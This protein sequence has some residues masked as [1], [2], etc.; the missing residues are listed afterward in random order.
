MAGGR[1]NWA[2]AEAKARSTK[3]AQEEA[4]KQAQEQAE[5]QGGFWGSDFGKG[6]GFV[7]NNPVTRAVSMP[8]N[9]LQTGGRAL[10]LG[11]ESLRKAQ[12]GGPEWLDQAL[13]A[14]PGLGPLLGT[15]N[16]ERIAKDDR[17]N[18]EKVLSPNSTYGYGSLLY[19]P[20]E[21]DTMPI[22][23]PFAKYNEA[24]SL[25]LGPT[26]LRNQARAAG[27][28]GDVAYDPLGATT[29]AATRT[30]EKA[31]DAARALQ[32]AQIAAE[33]L[34]ATEK[35]GDAERIA[36]ATQRAADTAAEAQRLA[37]I[38]E[39]NVARRVQVP[40]PRNRAERA[41]LMGELTET[42]GGRR[43]LTEMP[44]E[45]RQ[46]GVRGFQ[47]MS[48]EARQVLGI[49]EPGLSIR[50]LDV[51]I[52][53]T[54][55]I[56]QGI[57]WAGG[58]VRAGLAKPA[59]TSRLANIRVPR[60]LEDAFAVLT[61]DADGD[62]MRAASEV[63]GRNSIR[64]GEGSQLARGNRVL[65]N[66]VR[67]ELKK[68]GKD[69]I[70]RAVSEAETSPD[71]NIINKIAARLL[72]TYENVTGRAIDP[73]N[74]RDPATYFPHVL[75][76]KWRRALARMEKNRDRSAA[77]FLRAS[78]TRTE[79]LLEDN[80]FYLDNTLE[81]SGFLE[82]ARKLGPNPDGTP[83]TVK[84][85][86]TDVTFERGDIDHINEKLREAFPTWKGDFYDTDP[87]RVF[88]AYN[89][90]LARQA[91]RDVA[92][93]KF[94]T[95]GNPL[96]KEMVGNLDLSRQA[97][98]EALAQQGA[99]PLL[100]TAQGKYDPTQ[101]LPAIP[102]R[103]VVPGM[104]EDRA[105]RQA[106]EAAQ[107]AAT[108]ANTPEEAAAHAA[109]AAALPAPTERIGGIAPEDYFVTTKG[110]AA[111]A[112][113]D[114]QVKRAATYAKAAAAETRKADEALRE[115]IDDV[116]KSMVKP[117][118]TS[119]KET[120]TEISTINK[121]IKKWRKQVTEFGPMKEDNFDDMSVLVSKVED[122]ILNI[123]TKLK[124][125]AASWKG[126][127][128]RAQRKSEARLRE[129]LRQLK[130]VRDDVVK[131]AEQAPARMRE[132]FEFRRQALNKPV[133]DA[134]RA[135]LKA[136]FAHDLPPHPQAVV[137]AARKRISDTLE[138]QVD[139][140]KATMRERYGEILRQVD[141]LNG[142]RNKAGELSQTARKK[143]D[144]LVA[145]ADRLRNELGTGTGTKTVDPFRQAQEE[146]ASLAGRRDL[147]AAQKSR[148]ATL[149][150]MFGKGG[151]HY[152]RVQDEKVL[153][154]MEEYE[155]GLAAATKPQR[156]ALEAAQAEKRMRQEAI[157]WANRS[158]TM[159]HY[160]EEAGWGPGERRYVEPVESPPQRAAFGTEEDIPLPGGGTRKRP[161]P[162]PRTEEEALT[163]LGSQI[164]YGNAAQQGQRAV[165][166]RAQ[167]A[168]AAREAEVAE[169]QRTLR[170]RIAEEAATIEKDFAAQADEELGP[171]AARAQT[172]KNLA[173][174]LSDKRNLLKKRQE[175]V[176]LRDRLNKAN[177]TT[178][179]LDLG[180]TIDEIE[181]VAKAN[182]LLDDPKLNQ[183][184]SLLNTHRQ[185]LKRVRDTQ[186]RVDD[187]DRIVQDAN[188]GKLGDVM[189]A[190]LNNNWRALHAG[191]LNT[192]DVIMDAELHKRFTNLFELNRQPTALGRT[193]NAFTNLF[194]TYATLSPGFFVRNTIGGIF[195]N[196]ADGVALSAQA[197]GA[198]LFQQWMSKKSGGDDWLLAQ[199]KRVQ[200]AF[201][202]AF[203]SGAGGRF[204]DSGVLAQ[205][206]SKLYNFLSSNKV[207]RGAQ[208]FGTRVEGA[209][210]L[211]MALDSIDRGDD[212]GRAV[213]RITRIHF[214]YSQVS[215]LDDT[216]KRIIPFWTFMS[217][218]LP[219]QIQEMWTN[220]RVYSY[221][222]H[223]VQNFS[224]PD[225]EFT[226]DYWKRQGA[227]RTPL[228]IGGNPIYAQPDL[229]FTRVQQDI[230]ML[231]DALGGQNAG[232]LFAQGNPLI[233]ATYDFLA[234]RDS[235]Y[236][237]TY[238][239]KDYSKMEGPLGAIITP[240][241]QIAGQ[242]NE[243]G[244]VSD[245][246]MNYLTS[247]IPPLS[248]ATRIAPQVS[249][250]EGGADTWAKRARYIGV[251]TQ[252]LTP[253]QQKS[254]FWRRY[255]EQTDEA[256]RVQAMLEEA[257]S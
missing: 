48:P 91:G 170:P 146:L 110:T 33:A 176:V 52:P 114:A 60:G 165:F 140:A 16:Q 189:I 63:A 14:T 46:G 20:K 138:S 18:F 116:R 133:E 247:L 163:S 156:D 129:S 188:N 120:D 25:E 101:P 128:T 39:A 117:L 123:E 159:R 75:D 239:G 210:R 153:A 180:R 95:T 213:Q 242:T 67:Q 1:V 76:P 230:Q 181:S 80:A 24:D 64:V 99:A 108:A 236:D 222:D 231:G 254:E 240:L 172:Y 71:M 35:L 218:N 85:G 10:T 224:L 206:N 21:T 142:R 65:S 182:P 164:N 168:A 232:A 68:L 202:A 26:W 221:Y 144:A 115:S 11:L 125:T 234:H 23:N 152:Q 204:E 90:S 38:P 199:P 72:A 220:P 195:M 198:S 74:L 197:E 88:E 255:F 89:S 59:G 3:K 245:N 238:T 228:S 6:L 136:E 207:T 226:P 211:G 31:S 17:S 13:A 185:E 127:A 73:N 201:T 41:N 118:R 43:F 248:Q 55:K 34:R 107:A 135:L 27:L 147:D 103:P 49:S 216:M 179:R 160:G 62:L 84:I 32:E 124:R 158:K 37:A 154:A 126:R 252:L 227:W 237:R 53:G 2:E 22:S 44:G 121:A 113:R 93:K 40:L 98:D 246:F 175:N 203:T 139:P 86:D 137:D 97:M 200:D 79:E 102:E 250:G 70:R 149:Q 58:G 191:P 42:E 196:T 157:I 194:K 54:R 122:E 78:G 150:R 106:V 19:E 173:S 56:A 5:D 112:A 57:N 111:T 223:L 217:R 130:E 141:T 131:A 81:G 174:D 192:G 82:K 50:G 161:I 212:V 186:I 171:M 183:V 94:V 69:G 4:Q 148:R 83:R 7:I 253:K 241:A 92:A 61:R 215:D 45:A 257:A 47:T 145:E 96:V 193:F 66:A 219:M 134:Q 166:S 77:D 12:I 28:L 251:P 209:M 249:G 187:L 132:E 100:S 177:P 87:V 162:Q 9:Y 190:T 143:M 178:L 205:T 208:R 8:L 214:D 119:I 15:V 235:F 105:R 29:S 36:A 109:T 104:A 155:R 256:D 243:Q 167:R 244:Q 225:E 233:G 151:R 169:A 30:V 184:E 51:R 229:G